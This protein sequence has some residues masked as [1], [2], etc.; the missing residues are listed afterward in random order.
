MFSSKEIVEEKK[1][2]N[3]LVDKVSTLVESVEKQIGS[4]KQAKEDTALDIET[5]QQELTRMNKHIENLHGQLN[6][7]YEKNKTSLIFYGIPQDTVDREDCLKMKVREG[8]EII[9]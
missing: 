9:Y 1:K 8:L 4:E 7:I 5:L 2:I 6:E 3:A